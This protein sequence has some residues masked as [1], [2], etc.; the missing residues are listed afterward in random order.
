MF[1]LWR[2]IAGAE[3]I[4]AEPSRASLQGGT[5]KFGLEVVGESYYQKALRQAQRRAR[6][7]PEGLVI[8]VVV[9]PEPDNPYDA[10]A[11]CV[12]TANGDALLGHLSRD[13]AKQYKRALAEC[14]QAGFTV[15]CT[16][17]MR[18]GESDKP[19]IGIWLDLVFPAQLK[20]LLKGRLNDSQA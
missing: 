14:A 5:G 18:G 10:D 17:V 8:D 19:N 12:V 9:R 11:V 2:R 20:S 7:T 13:R 4:I 15:E 6:K 3:T 1:K 16:A